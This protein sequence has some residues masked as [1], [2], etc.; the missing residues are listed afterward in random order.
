MNYK[1]NEKIKKWK[2]LWNNSDKL[3]YWRV[4]VRIEVVKVVGNMKLIISN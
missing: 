3:S 4:K 2:K 1:K